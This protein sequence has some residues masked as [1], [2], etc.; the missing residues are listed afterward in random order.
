[1]I[2]P[3]APV[4]AFDF[5]GTLT[6]HD[7][8]FPF[9]LHAM[10]A[11]PL[12]AAATRHGLALAQ[13]AAG[14]GDRD[15]TKADF[16]GDLLRG[17]SRDRLELAAMQRANRTI[18]RG[19]RRDT[20]ARLRWH[21]E[22]GHHVV[23]VSASPDFVVEPVARALGAHHVIATQIEFVDGRCTGQLLGGNVRGP[24][25]VNRLRAHYGDAIE[26]EWAY[27]DSSG[28]TDMLALARN[29]VFV[30]KTMVSVVPA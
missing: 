26:L 13:V 25:K 30:K 8:M 4:V 12:T 5:D 2:E 21:R 15:A 23:V 7:T 29:P 6:R 1:M 19:L 9:L 11:A 22:Q 16:V 24:E 27:G 17:V 3:D 18:A 20:P 14:R 28:D 10:G